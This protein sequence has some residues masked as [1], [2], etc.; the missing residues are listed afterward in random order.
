F[1]GIIGLALEAP[2]RCHFGYAQC[3]PE[4]FGSPRSTLRRT[5]G[6][7]AVVLDPLS[8]GQRTK[9]DKYRALSPV[10]PKYRAQGQRAA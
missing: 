9:G 4:P 1:V 6:P 10:R 2:K 5:P 7:L 8:L 3:R